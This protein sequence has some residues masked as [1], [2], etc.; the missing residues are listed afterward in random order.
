V[1]LKTEP[2]S[3]PRPARAST[4]IFPPLCSTI[5]LQ[6]ARPIPLPGYSVRA[7]RLEDYKNIL[8][9]FRRNADPVIAHAEQPLLARFLGLHG[10]RR[11]FFPAKL[12]RVPDQILDT[13]FGLVPEQ[14]P[15]PPLL[16]YRLFRITTLAWV[17]VPCAWIV[18]ETWSFTQSGVVPAV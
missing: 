18:K 11:R 9:V 12:D 7:W 5:F 13:T 16:T 6:I 2:W 14:N 17:E 15:L 8:R 10:N 3:E 4:Q 1:N